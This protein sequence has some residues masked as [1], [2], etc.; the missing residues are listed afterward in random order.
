MQENWPT[1]KHRLSSHL[2]S[3]SEARHML[4]EAGCP[5]EPEQIGISRDRLRRSYLQA[6]FIRRRFT[7]LDAV[8]MWGLT[9]TL[10]DRM[11]AAGG[12]WSR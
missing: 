9:D 2:L 8:A 4:A 6:R 3:F 1:L 5:T 12:C 10:L 7:V 11:F